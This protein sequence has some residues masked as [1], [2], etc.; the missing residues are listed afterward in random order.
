M[1]GDRGTV[2]FTLANTA[3]SNSVVVDDEEFDTNA[4]VQSATLEGVDGIEVTTGTYQ[5]KGIIGPGESLNLTYSIKVAD[6]AEDGTYYLD[7]STVGSSHEYNNNWR[8]PV[9]VDSSSVRVIP[10]TPLNLKNGVGTIEFDVA[11]IHP[12]ALSSV[13]IRLEAEG[14]DFSPDEYFIGAMDP[15]ELFT[16]EFDV[17]ASD[18]TDFSAD[19]VI[20]ADYRNGLNDHSSVV[21]VREIKNTVVRENNQLGI[22][23]GV[24][25]VIAIAA[26]GYMMYR[27]RKEKE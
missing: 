2:R 23:I 16:I 4:R 14:F 24:I 13:S 6:E 9:K 8:I 11:N 5:G 1:P 26:G 27:R 22:A 15:D 3:T 19:L 12:N 20:N 7:F 21:G 18:D 17:N 25:V 10:S